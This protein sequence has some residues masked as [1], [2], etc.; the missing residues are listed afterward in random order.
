MRTLCLSYARGGHPAPFLLRA[1]GSAERLHASG[2]L[3][4]IFP[5]ERF[6]P[7]QV[8]LAPGDRLVVY[9]DGAED[10]L[11]PP[12]HA[13]G[14]PLLDELQRLRSLPADEAAL[15]L[16]VHIDSRRPNARTDDDITVV[17]MDI[18]RP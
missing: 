3:L 9:S 17:F 4:G 6:E 15:Q 2:A 7:R 8:V 16:A 14:N 5:Q 12:A 13:E 18:L 1:G 11:H 10:L